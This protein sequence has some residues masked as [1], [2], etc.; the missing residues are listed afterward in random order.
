MAEQGKNLLI[1]FDLVATLTDAGPRYVRAFSDMCERFGYPKPDE[2]EV[3]EMLGNKNLKEITQ[4][5][6][7]DIDTGL[8]GKFMNSCNK[9]CDAMLFRDDWQETLFPHVRETLED[10]A[11]EGYKLGIYTGTREDALEDQITYHGIKPL[12]QQDYIRGKDNTRDAGLDSRTL[13]AAQLESIVAQYRKDCGDDNAPV[14][15]IGDSASDAEAAAD[16]GYL[17]IGFAA[18]ERKKEKLQNSGVKFLMTDFEDL[19]LLIKG[20]TGAVP[21]E[22]RQ[23]YTK[24]KKKHPPQP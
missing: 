24:V 21:A 4:H 2:D 3:M 7:G 5:F 18:S 13:K 10:L 6:L 12:F 16:Q 20:A 11:A 15:V 8:Q 19:P 22:E 9:E 23:N 1:V 17:F 14:L